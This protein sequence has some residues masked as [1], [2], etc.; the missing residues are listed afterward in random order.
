MAPRE[1]NSSCRVFFDVFDL[2]KV[3]APVVWNYYIKRR[4][5]RGMCWTN[6]QRTIVFICWGPPKS[7]YM[8]HPHDRG[9]AK[10]YCQVFQNY[11][12]GHYSSIFLFLHTTNAQ[13]FPKYWCVNPISTLS[14]NL[15]DRD[16]NGNGNV[17]LYST[18]LQATF[19][20][21][22]SILLFIW[23]PWTLITY[24]FLTHS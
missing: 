9:L 13:S 4:E 21:C 17:S 1:F 24:F 8:Y 14:P 7:L 18:H 19:E 5:K 22:E 3:S 23:L 2:T 6:R 16:T 15:V 20:W 10:T 12:I 11:K